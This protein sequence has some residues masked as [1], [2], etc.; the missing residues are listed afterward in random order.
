MPFSIDPHTLM[1][2]DT[3]P[4]YRVFR[5]LAINPL[6]HQDFAEHGR[7]PVIQFYRYASSRIQCSKCALRASQLAK[8]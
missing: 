8:T 5:E 6:V 4:S 3:P 2:N 7:M 1:P